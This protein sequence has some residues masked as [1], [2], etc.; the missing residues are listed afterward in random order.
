MKPKRTTLVTALVVAGI[1][2]PCLA[3]YFAGSRAA[4]EQAQRLRERPL[5]AAK[6]D[7]DRLAHVVGIRLEALREAES[8]RPHTDYQ[9]DDEPFSVGCLIEE[10]LGGSPLSM[11][12]SDPLIWAYFQIDSVGELSLPTSP[13]GDESELATSPSGESLNDEIAEALE[14]AASDYLESI[15]QSADRKGRRIVDAPEGTVIV[16]PFSWHTVTLEGKPSL[17]ALR[18]IDSP[19]ADRTQGFVVANEAL[20]ELVADSPYPAIVRPGEPADDSQASLPLSSEEWTVEL[21]LTI[22]LLAAERESKVILNRFQRSFAIGAMLALLA[23]VAIVI[24]VYR[25]ERL[26]SER[27]RFAAS[28]AHELRT[29]LAGMR[30]YAEMLAEGL[31][32]PQKR[33]NYARRIADETQ[34]L[35]RVVTNVLGFAQLQRDGVQVR[36]ERGD[37]AAATRKSVEQ[38][39]PAIEAAGASVDLQLDEQLA[40]T[41]FDPDAVHQILQNLLDNAEKYTRESDDRRIE[42]ELNAN[43]AGPVLSVRDHGPGVDRALRRRL[44]EPFERSGRADL[45]AGLGVGLALV[46]ALAGAQGATVSH[47]TPEDGGSRFEV[48]FPA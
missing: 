38:L 27:A 45:P 6:L 18:E 9:P 28:A 46:R 41:P 35:G 48:H 3:W 19:L 22:P 26:A 16:G 23:G 10:P 17:V 5:A 43:G 47:A 36:M 42:I 29:P 39:A 31:G 37:L 34:R 25:A 8:R 44:F 1:L 14:C 24:V 15:K 33:E 13:T 4:F 30:M 20:A 2:V 32:A 11:G 21:D 40:P 12:P 7:A